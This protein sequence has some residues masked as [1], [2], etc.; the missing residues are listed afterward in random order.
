MTGLDRTVIM[1]AWAKLETEWDNDQAHRRFIAL[2]ANNDALDEAGRLYR[3]VRDSDPSR[4]DE[5]AR[6]LN[7]ILAAAFQ[8]LSPQ[9]GE[10]PRTRR[11]M[12][13]IVGACG[14]V[15]AHAVLTLLRH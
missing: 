8:Q 15:L 5:A 6:R 1:A 13:L 2:C 11:M 12:W 3:T 9:R 7:A 10:P 14:F 4:R